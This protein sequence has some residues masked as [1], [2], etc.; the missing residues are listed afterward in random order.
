MKKISY[1]IGKISETG[2]RD[3]ILATRYET[4][5]EAQTAAEARQTAEGGTFEAVEIQEDVNEEGENS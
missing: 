1:V 3:L 4:L 2:M 5:E